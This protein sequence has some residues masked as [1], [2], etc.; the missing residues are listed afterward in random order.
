M[1]HG[2]GT[3]ALISKIK[4]FPQCMK[5]FHK[6]WMYNYE[7]IANI[8]GFIDFQGRMWENISEFITKIGKHCL[9]I[10]LQ[11]QKR[12]RMQSVSSS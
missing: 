4:S 1:K 3:V 6:Q 5:S 7:E 8:Y 9:M 12:E 10:S 2:N 11:N